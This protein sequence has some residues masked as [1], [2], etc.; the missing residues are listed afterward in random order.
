MRFLR[1]MVLRQ[2][3]GHIGRAVGRSAMWVSNIEAGNIENPSPEALAVLA[4]V[5]GVTPPEKLLEEITEAE[6]DAIADAWRTAAAQI[7]IALPERNATK[8]K[9]SRARKRV[10]R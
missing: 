2:T 1:T 4:K 10:R 6:I 3:Q 8:P 5:F 7:G 9:Q